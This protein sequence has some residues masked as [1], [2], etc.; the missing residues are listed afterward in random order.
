M[1]I[2]LVVIMEWNKV[3]S[4]LLLRGHWNIVKWKNNLILRTDFWTVKK[5]DLKV[6]QN[7][8]QYLDFDGLL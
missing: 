7:S 4:F 2:L 5:Y 6:A 1:A 8:F 3:L